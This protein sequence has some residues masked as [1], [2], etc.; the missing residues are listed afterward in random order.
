MADASS[1]FDCCAPAYAE[2]HGDAAC[3]LKP[4]GR[5]FCL[6]LNG[7]YVWY[8]MLAPL[9][10][11]ETRHLSTD[12]FLTEAKFV[13]MLA[14]ARFGRIRAGYWTFIPK[15]DMPPAI[16]AILN[17]MDAMAKALRLNSLR[18]GL[19]VSAEKEER[20]LKD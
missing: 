2:Q 17:R 14:I 12:R 16:G 4:V 5:F 18:G 11:L 7:G 13:Q 1:F 3:L 8:K 10:G 20:M 15:G 9:L 6:T 19:L